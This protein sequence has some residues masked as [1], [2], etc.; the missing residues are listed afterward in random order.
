MYSPTQSILVV[1]TAVGVVAFFFCVRLL[2]FI[3][4]SV[5]GGGV[6]VGHDIPGT[7]QDPIPMY[8]T[9]EEKQL[10]KQAEIGRKKYV[11]KREPLY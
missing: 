6:V 7:G 5:V 10:E 8:T 3:C 9:K 11:G 2:C 1:I 4:F